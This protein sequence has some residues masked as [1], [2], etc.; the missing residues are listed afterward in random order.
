MPRK[1]NS[2]AGVILTAIA[3]V[4][5]TAFLI[6]I[7]GQTAAAVNDFDFVAAADFGCTSNT[8]KTITNMAGKNPEIAFAMG[9]L[10]YTSTPDCWFKETASLD[11]IMKIAIG[12]EDVTNTTL[13]NQYLDHYA[14]H[15]RYYSFD[16]QNVHFTIFDTDL[17]YRGTDST[18]VAWVKDDL[19]N[20]DANPNITWKVVI[21]HRASAFTSYSTL[22]RDTFNPIFDQ[23]GVDLVMFGH[24]HNYERGFPMKYNSQSPSNPIVTDTDPNTYSDPEGVIYVKIGTGGH[25]LNGCDLH[26]RQPG[27]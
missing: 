9:D 5:F 2:I 14:P 3:N 23:H 12:N 17:G 25:S 13:L 1:Y 7:P 6:Q 27:D 24:N 4:L 19:S 20:A 18:Q 10:S 21:F 22:V 15:E 16:Y 26:D 8:S 11:S